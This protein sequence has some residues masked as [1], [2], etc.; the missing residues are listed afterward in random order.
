MLRV[1]LVRERVSG[2]QVPEK[3]YFETM[4]SDEVCFVFGDRETATVKGLMAD[5]L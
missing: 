3:R 1:S 5:A 4:G 2:Q